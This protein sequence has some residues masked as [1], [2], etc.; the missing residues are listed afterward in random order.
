MIFCYQQV[1]HRTS[2]AE[3]WNH[4]ALSRIGEGGIGYNILFQPLPMPRFPGPL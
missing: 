2:V 3:H 4:A 1:Y